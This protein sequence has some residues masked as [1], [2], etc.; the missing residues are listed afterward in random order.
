MRR[1]K[2]TN[3]A[4]EPMKM[5]RNSKIKNVAVLLTCVNPFLLLNLNLFNTSY[6]NTQ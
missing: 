2:R 6:K 4:N 1:G 3:E 5:N